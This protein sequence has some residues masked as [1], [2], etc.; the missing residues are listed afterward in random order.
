MI[1]NK[2]RKLKRLKKIVFYFVFIIKIKDE[3]VSYDFF[4]FFIL[5]LKGFCQYS[6]KIQLK[7]TFV[8][9]SIKET[10]QVLIKRN[11]AFV[12]ANDMTHLSV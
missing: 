4:F 7:Y 8:L 2:Q 9:R 11:G 10:F 5:V 12:H 6:G 1:E 3:H